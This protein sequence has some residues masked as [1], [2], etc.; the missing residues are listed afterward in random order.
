MACSKCGKRVGRNAKFCSGCGAALTGPAE[1]AE[2]IE[3]RQIT[4][5]FCDLM[6]S[7]SM[8]GRLDA[9]DLREVMLAYRNAALV[10][11]GRS[12]GHVAG[13]AGDGILAVFGY[14]VAREDDARVAVS[15]A[16]EFCGAIPE[17]SQRMGRLYGASLCVRVGIHTGLIVID[18]GTP[19]HASRQ[20]SL[21]GNSLNIGARLQEIARPNGV[22]VS[23]QTYDLVQ[24]HFIVED[25][26]PQTLKG[27]ASPL[28]VYRVIEARVVR[29]IFEA[30]LARGLSE[31]VGRTAEM[32]S[33]E[34]EWTRALHGEP[35][36]VLLAGDPGIGKSR[37][38]YEFQLRR[39]REDC[40]R[41]M[42]QCS[43]RDQNT[44]F[45]PIATEL[46]RTFHIEPHDR[47]EAR[48]A[49]IAAG[50]QRVGIHS[51]DTADS[52]SAMFGDRDRHDLGGAPADEPGRSASLRHGIIQAMMDY[53]AAAAS[54]LPLLLIFEDLHW[55]DPSTLELLARL[56]SSLQSVPVLILCS[57]RRGVHVEMAPDRVIGMDRISATDCQRLIDL[58]AGRGALPR[59]VVAE[60]MHRSDGVPLF[61]E[62]LTRSA[63]EALDRDQTAG[64]ADGRGAR[65]VVPASLQDSIMARLDRV[66]SA[67]RVAQ[68]GSLIGRSF[69]ADLLARLW[70]GRPQ[71]LERDVARLVDAEILFAHQSA[72]PGRA[73]L[74]FRHE[75]VRGVASESMPRGE[76][77]AMHAR[78]AHTLERD[79]ADE[80]A[81]QPELLAHHWTQAAAPGRALPLWELAGRR[82]VRASANQEAIGHFMRALG[83][84]DGIA[85]ETARRSKELDLHLSLASPLMAAKGY[86][87]PELDRTIARAM[88]LSKELGDA[89][90]VLPLI[91]GRWS[92][93][94]TTGQIRRSRDLALEYLDLAEQSDDAERQMVA[95]RLAGTSLQVTGHPE[96][97][98]RLL[99]RS[100]LLFDDASHG[101]LAYRYGADLKVMSQCSL[102]LASWL[103][104]RHEDADRA[105]DAAWQRS[106]RINHVNTS[107]YCSS[108]RLAL[109]AISG[110]IQDVEAANA[111]FSALLAQHKLPF[112]SAI[113]MGFAGWLRMRH[114][115]TA[116]AVTALED[117][118]ARME[119]VSVLYWRPTVWMW[120]GEALG[121][122]A[123]FTEA[124]AAFQQAAEL[125]ERSGECWAEPEIYRLWAAMR[126]ESGTA[127]ADLLAAR[128]VAAATAQG[129]IG[130]LQR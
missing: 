32:H 45:H 58:I 111:E 22:V 128:S 56:A 9:E 121:R 114:G 84:L 24:G 54:R 28:L 85:D 13:F 50:L 123:R 77:R 29:S 39:E 14:P 113:A 119:A 34:A 110:R 65:P 102:A 59:E 7:T 67:K 108:Y 95:F 57:V 3:R 47:D 48:R 99:S 94:Q 30:R 120:L 109:G 8:A 72:G 92:F 11:L 71:D 93:D 19:G 81:R 35:R 26:G 98:A 68:A 89:S 70:D 15:A 91:Y 52:M 82:A 90:R 69:S 88:E 100:I 27:L 74:E 127:G 31:V 53:V 55:S 60:L 96:A 75:L 122:S 62:E 63:V 76:Q 1:P 42:I 5:V 83:L 86:G 46:G 20:M 36:S 105:I 103:L 107:A 116:E 40:S 18:D 78:I 104:G 117:S 10:T 126:A 33:L 112:W 73:V 4:A 21:I 64:G 37:L 41:V 118:I 129:A 38:L 115:E 97:A 125:I 130:W 12:N 124:E 87:A 6:D 106:L 61:I 66:G 25:M 23:R 80:A 49:K 79:F 43:T 2:R 16:L 51:V 17:L 44:A 101:A